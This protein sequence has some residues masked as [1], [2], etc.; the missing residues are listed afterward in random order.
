MPHPR[1][2][3][4]PT[5][6]D[7]PDGVLQAL[8]D[9]FAAVRAELGLSLDYPADALAEAEQ[10]AASPP[11]LPERDETGL[12][13]FTIDPPGSM[14]LD[15]AMHLERDGDGHRI[16][17]AIADVPAFVR[18]GRRARPGDPRARARPSTAPTCGCRCTPRC[19]PRRPRAC[20]R[21]PCAPP[22]SG[23]CGSTATGR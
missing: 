14:D 16:R 6:A 19:C 20:C 12:P 17:Y 18:L 15:Q 22:S 13:F 23:T 2:R 1:V 4:A 5:D 9:R 3:L 8:R 7:I 10:V 21:M 11:D